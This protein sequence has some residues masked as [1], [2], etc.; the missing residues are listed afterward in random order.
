MT[1]VFHYST[2]R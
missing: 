1:K 2:Y